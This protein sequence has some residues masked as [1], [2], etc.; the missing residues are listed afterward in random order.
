M[1]SGADRSRRERRKS[2]RAYFSRDRFIQFNLVNA[3][4]VTASLLTTH[5]ALSTVAPPLNLVLPFQN[6]SL[7]LSLSSSSLQVEMVARICWPSVSFNFSSH[8]NRGE[9]TWDASWQRQSRLSRISCAE[10]RVVFCILVFFR[11]CYH[12]CVARL[13]GLD[14]FACGAHRNEKVGEGREILISRSPRGELIRRD[15]IKFES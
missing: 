14:G 5:V 1:D 9:G 10:K 8:R 11:G 3:T 12:G 2:R 7:S 13:A 4:S 6:L 15:F